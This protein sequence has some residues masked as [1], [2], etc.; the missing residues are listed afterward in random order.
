MSPFPVPIATTAGDDVVPIRAITEVVSP[1]PPASPINFMCDVD[2]SKYLLLDYESDDLEEEVEKYNELY[3]HEDE[4][5][6]FF[7][8]L[9]THTVG[10][11]QTV[12]FNSG[13][14]LALK[15][16]GRILLERRKSNISV[17]RSSTRIC[18]TRSPKGCYRI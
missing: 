3:E 17:P 4:D 11:L 10:G 12:V 7:R 13:D 6:H 18:T 5:L 14:L 16:K 1:S 8:N 9:A 2:I 15:E